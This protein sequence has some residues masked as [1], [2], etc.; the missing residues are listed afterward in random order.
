[1]VD[2]L[3]V[4]IPARPSERSRP[5][6]T[7]REFLLPLAGAA[8]IAPALRLV[9]RGM[10]SIFMLHR[11]TDPAL[12]V[13]GTD[14]A[15]LREQLAYLRRHRYRVLG[16]RDVLESFADDADTAEAPAVAFKIGRASCRER[17]EISVVAV[18]LKKK[19]VRQ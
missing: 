12:G 13:V 3:A 11:F 18:S 5:G 16:M 17:V 15:V 1:M 7:S 10:L 6:M 2:R 19:K 14:P 8:A 9:G 4:P